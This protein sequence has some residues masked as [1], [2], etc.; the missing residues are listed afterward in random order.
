M[1][2][3]IKKRF[4]KKKHD[5]LEELITRTRN[6]MQNNYKDM[7]QDYFKKFCALYNELQFSSSL[8]EKQTEY[9]DLERETLSK[10]LEG[11]THK[12]QKPYWH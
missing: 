9:Y 11:F 1:F 5:S 6:S 10:E 7:A 8:N 4:Q 3:S 2:E 12:D